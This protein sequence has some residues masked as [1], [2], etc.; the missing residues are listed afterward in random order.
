MMECLLYFLPTQTAPQCHL[1]EPLFNSTAELEFSMVRSA[2]TI[3][4]VFIACHQHS[5]TVVQ[6]CLMWSV[7]VSFDLQCSASEVVSVQYWSNC[8]E[9]ELWSVRSETL[10]QMS[11]LNFTQHAVNRDTIT[12]APTVYDMMEKKRRY[13]SDIDISRYSRQQYQYWY[14]TVVSSHPRMAQWQSNCSVVIQILT[15][16]F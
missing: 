9:K 13:R 6:L 4:L 5:H 14:Q 16:Y 11:Q 1:S 8:E 3:S 2:T 15:F 12:S 7:I 10:A